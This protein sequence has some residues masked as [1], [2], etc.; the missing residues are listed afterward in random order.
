[1]N[2][3]KTELLQDQAFRLVNLFHQKEMAIFASHD[4]N[5]DYYCRVEHAHRRASLRWSRRTD[6]HLKSLQL[7]SDNSRH[8]F[9]KLLESHYPDGFAPSSV[10]SSGV[11]GQGATI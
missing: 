1:M 9:Q 4:F 10:L 11:L 8:V 7:T 2:I 5:I 6:Q 3:N